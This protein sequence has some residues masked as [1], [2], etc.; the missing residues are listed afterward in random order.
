MLNDLKKLLFGAKSVAKSAGKKAVDA[1]KEATEEL[2]DKSKEYLEKAKKKAEELNE[3]YAPKVKEALDEARHFAEE[4]VDEAWKKGEELTTKAKQKADEF[5][6]SE[7]P[8]DDTPVAEQEDASTSTTFQSGLVDDD[9]S[10]DDL[11]SVLGQTEEETNDPNQTSTESELDKIGKKVQGVTEEVGKKVI[12]QGEKAWEKFQDVSEKVGK[13]VLDTSEEV[14]GK[15]FEKAT[16]AGSVIKGKFDELVEKANEAA[17]QEPSFDELTEE[18]KKKAEELEQRIKERGE[19]SNVENL[20][21]DE[22]KGPLGGFDSFFDKASR[23]ADGD[24][25]NEGEGHMKIQKDPDFKPES[26]EGAVKGFEDLDGDGNEII[27]DAIID[28]DDPDKA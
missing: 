10:L 27:D 20:K 21:A 4:I 25:H 2:G 8:T 13:K 7:E 17:A 15:I 11:D 14:G 16:E 1:G 5:F 3:E 9:S 24:Y 28:D 6:H 18:A 12:E 19:R 22:E 26:R 23:Y